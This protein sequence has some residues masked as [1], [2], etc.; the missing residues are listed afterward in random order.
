MRLLLTHDIKR[1]D[2]DVRGLYGWSR[3]DGGW[4][5]ADFE[6]VRPTGDPCDLLVM[7]R[8]DIAY[9]SDDLTDD[10]LSLA[11]RIAR[12]KHIDLCDLS[13]EPAENVAWDV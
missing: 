5:D 7:G 11:T 1:A 13:G 2:F 12:T 6:F 8:D 9:V 10:E 4:R 3:E